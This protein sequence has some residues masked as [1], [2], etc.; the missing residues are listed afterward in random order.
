MKGI[1][2]A[3]RSRRPALLV[4]LAAAALLLGACG[5]EEA[6]GG[7]GA[8]VSARPAQA[9]I[10]LTSTDTLTPFEM[11]SGRYKFGWE[12]RECPGVE[13]TLTGATQGFIYTKK[14]AQKAF[15][16]I[17]SEVPADT[18]TLAQINPACTVWTVRIDRI[19][20]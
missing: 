7:D 3:T 14:S 4:G 5:G 2:M 15:S 17:V 9:K 8:P 6:G 13:F 1:L 20:N 12:A 10:T 18:Y 16:A 11:Q 19:G